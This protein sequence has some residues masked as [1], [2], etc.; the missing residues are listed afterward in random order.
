M[1]NPRDPKLPPN[2]AILQIHAEVERIA[3]T[4]GLDKLLTG[5]RDE[6]LSIRQRIVDLEAEYTHQLSVGLLAIDEKLDR[7]RSNAA[8]E[9]R[10]LEE[11]KT[12]LQSD[13]KLL[14]R[15]IEETKAGEEH[16]VEELRTEWIKVQ[17]A[18]KALAADMD[19]EK[20]RK[21]LSIERQ[22]FEKRIS[23]ERALQRGTAKKNL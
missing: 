20:A 19:V 14:L 16:R 12:R 6:E 2:Q 3:S 10:K 15:Q 11:R 8:T 7:A 1:T 4:I 9:E 5:L 22:E 23:E 18:R 13:L 21:A 17:A